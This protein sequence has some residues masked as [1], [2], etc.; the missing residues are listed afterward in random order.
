MDV[1]TTRPRLVLGAAALLCVLVVPIAAGDV[2]GGSDDGQATAAASVKKKLKKLKKKVTGLEQ[3]L[4]VLEEE[5][6]SPRPPLGPA[7]GDLR[8]SFPN[9]VIGP[10]AVGTTEVA[11]NSLTGADINEGT[12]NLQAEAVSVNSANNSSSGKSATAPCGQRQ[13]LGFGA[14]LNNVL[15]GSV[16][17]AVAN[18][19]ITGVFPT[20]TPDGEAVTATAAELPGANYDQSWFVTAR[21]ICASVAG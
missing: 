19:V 10:S 11:P 7:G 14:T 21:A 2:P 12:L 8:G 16:P 9:P 5:Q 15:T 20:V 13:V 18:V 3:R 1:T 17:D 4:A 6:G